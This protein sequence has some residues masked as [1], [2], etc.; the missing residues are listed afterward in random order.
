MDILVGCLESSFRSRRNWRNGALTRIECRPK[1]VVTGTEQKAFKIN[2]F[3]LYVIFLT[4]A[5]LSTSKMI[6]LSYYSEW[7]SYIFFTSTCPIS[8]SS[9]SVRPVSLLL[10]RTSS[11]CFSDPLVLFAS[12]F[13]A[14]SSPR[15]N[16]L[17]LIIRTLITTAADAKDACTRKTR[18][19]PRVYP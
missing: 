13:R 9:P 6:T 1:G 10:P 18:R 5:Q 14:S 15:T 17:C 2:Q 7:H 4:P 11:A 12:A 16:S 3:D 19:K 8:K